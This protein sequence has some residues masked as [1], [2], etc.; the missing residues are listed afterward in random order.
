M[1][2]NKILFPAALLVMIFCILASWVLILQYDIMFPVCFGAVPA[3]VLAAM[4]TSNFAMFSGLA[5]ALILYVVV[6]LGFCMR[7]QKW[8]FIMGL[9]GLCLDLALNIVFVSFS[10]GYL[11]AVLLDV[12]LMLTLI[13][14]KKTV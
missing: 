14:L 3:M 2:N 11:I 7:K 12:V 4:F 8:G 13:S 6:L 10:W 5:F 1:K 9:V